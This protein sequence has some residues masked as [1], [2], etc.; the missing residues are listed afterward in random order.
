MKYKALNELWLAVEEL[1]KN[2]HPP[3]NWLEII[4]SMNARIT[5]FEKTLGEL[6]EAMDG[7]RDDG[8]QETSHPH[9]K[10]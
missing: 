9:P 6:K 1:Q 5:E 10:K 7:G 3:V 2:S 4:E 8:N